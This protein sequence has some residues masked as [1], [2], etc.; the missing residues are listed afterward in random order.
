MKHDLS[1][2]IFVF[3]SKISYIIND[4]KPRK[5]GAGIIL[6][7]MIIIIMRNAENSENANK[8]QSHRNP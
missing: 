5:S 7:S 1:Q 4:I 8:N 6:R 3:E 2:A